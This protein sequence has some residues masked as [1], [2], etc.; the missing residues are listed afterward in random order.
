MSAGRLA[1]VRLL[2]AFWLGSAIFLV[3]VAA[4]AAFRGAGGPSAAADVVGLML[5][6]WHYI[7]LVVPVILLLLNLRRGRSLVVALLTLVIFFAAM[8]GMVDL[9]ARA[10]R[11]SSVVPISSLE[12]AHPVRR[13]FGRLHGFSMM[14][15]AAQIVGGMAIVAAGAFTSW[16][17]QMGEVVPV[18][19][20]PAPMEGPPPPAAPH[21]VSY[22]VTIIEQRD[23][24][25]APSVDEQE[26]EKRDPPSPS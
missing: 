21:S 22:G 13:Q 26:G 6:R 8:Q 17:E 14:L 25:F 23:S 5:T 1:L 9:R 3:T 16:R 2:E 24:E 7:A 18:A 10:L 11:V 19:T 20:I 4:P 15:L 12:P